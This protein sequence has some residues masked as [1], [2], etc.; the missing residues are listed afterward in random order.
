M[1]FTENEA[2]NRLFCV[3]KSCQTLPSLRIRTTAKKTSL[4]RGVG[5]TT[6]S[7]WGLPRSVGTTTGR[8]W[9]PLPR[10]FSL[11]LFAAS[12]QNLL[13]SDSGHDL[14]VLGIFG[15]L[16]LPFFIYKASRSLVYQH[17]LGSQDQ[18]L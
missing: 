6:S 4:I 5:P 1:E 17:A 10:S 18:N 2:G 12:F 9:W 3:N 15:P 11:T 16:L 8:P 14:S 13:D 7:L